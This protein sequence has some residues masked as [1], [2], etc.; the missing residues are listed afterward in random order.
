MTQA[1]RN[2][3]GGKTVISIE[4]GIIRLEHHRGSVCIEKRSY[5]AQDLIDGN[6]DQMLFNSSLGSVNLTTVK[7]I[8]K[9]VDPFDLSDLSQM[10]DYGGEW[11]QGEVLKTP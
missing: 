10:G 11:A 3:E 2:C 1:T 8:S 7:G 5:T 9:G 6:I 4:M